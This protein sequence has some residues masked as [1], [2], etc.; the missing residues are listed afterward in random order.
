[1]D[2]QLRFHLG[3][4]TVDLTIEDYLPKHSTLI[5]L[6]PQITL[7]WEQNSL[8]FRPL[9]SSQCPRNEKCR[10]KQSSPSPFSISFSTWSKATIC[11]TLQENPPNHYMIKQKKI[12]K[13]TLAETQSSLYQTQASSKTSQSSKSPT[14]PL[15]KSQ[16]NQMGHGHGLDVCRR[17]RSFRPLLFLRFLYS[18]SK[19]LPNFRFM[20]NSYV[21]LLFHRRIG[22]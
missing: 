10:Y 7:G 17:G 16:S 18:A 2:K 14:N 6:W 3:K 1:M 4:H 9:F 20:E 11:G 5:N 21:L 13:L 15:M 8:F 12:C 22:R 19:S